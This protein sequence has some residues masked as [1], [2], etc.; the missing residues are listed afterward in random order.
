H[1]L[2]ER[3]LDIIKCQA[4]GL[5]SSQIAEKLFIS[6]HTVKTHRKN[7]LRKLDLHSSSELIQYALNNG[8]I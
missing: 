4:E 2:S 7:I 5:T 8:I 1:R 6:L 3:E